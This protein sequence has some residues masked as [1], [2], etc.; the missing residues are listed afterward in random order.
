MKLFGF[1]IKITFEHLLIVAAVAVIALGAY[2]LFYSG[3]GLGARLTERLGF[4]YLSPPVA[5]NTAGGPRAYMPAETKL[6]ELPVGGKAAELGATTTWFAQGGKIGGMD[7]IPDPIDMGYDRPREL[8]IY[9]T[10]PTGAGP[11]PANVII[12]ARRPMRGTEL[13]STVQPAAVPD[14]KELLPMSDTASL[15]DVDPTVTGPGQP[16]LTSLKDKNND[17]SGRSIDFSNKRV[18]ASLNDAGGPMP[19]GIQG[20]TAEGFMTV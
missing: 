20:V 17:L 1:K 19:A 18:T 15:L 14:G 10:N 11:A 8:D 16:V 9:T 2:L 5:G 6:D 13:S 3:E 4:R 12:G 7:R